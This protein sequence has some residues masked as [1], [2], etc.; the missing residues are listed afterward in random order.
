V[1]EDGGERRAGGTQVG[2][3]AGRQART[4]VLC[5]HVQRECPGVVCVREREE[6]G[7]QRARGR[8]AI[9][10]NQTPT[11]VKFG[12][13]RVLGR[14]VFATVGGTVRRWAVIK[15]KVVVIMHNDHN[16]SDKSVWVN[17]LVH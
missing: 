5:V 17:R 1:R 16:N 10:D 14:D 9:V 3:Q 11:I 13:E 7:L 4:V 6:R 8:R 12:E 15:S 2:R